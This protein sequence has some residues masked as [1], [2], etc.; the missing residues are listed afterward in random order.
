[1]QQTA[2]PHMSLRSKPI[3]CARLHGA[4]RIALLAILAFTAIGAPSPT[5]A[6]EMANDPKG[7]RGIAWGSA[8]G[9]TANLTLVASSDRIKEYDVKPSPQLLGEATVDSMHYVTIDDKFARVTI[10]YQGQ[11]THRQVMTYLQSQ[12]GPIDRTPG[13][14]AAG[15]LQQFNWRGVETEVN[16]TYEVK[17]DRGLL[18]IESRALAPIFTESLGGQ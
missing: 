8:L 17:R 15:S 16:L 6:V 12:F 11:K 1:M 2:R 13:Q 5:Q 7:F 4:L 18:F 9:E 3:P 14:M 10:R